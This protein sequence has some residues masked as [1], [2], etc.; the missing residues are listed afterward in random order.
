MSLGVC[1]W[2]LNIYEFKLQFVL[3]Y[4]FRVKELG[5][6]GPVEGK[7]SDYSPTA[8]NGGGLSPQK[9]DLEVLRNANVSNV[10]RCLFHLKAQ[11][12]MQ[13]A[14]LVY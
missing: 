4:C 8:G 9:S 7:S 13:Y 1:C 14:N 5:P 11:Q 2:E 6:G 10:W 12:N 3:L